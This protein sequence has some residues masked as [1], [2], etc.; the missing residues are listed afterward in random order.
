MSTVGLFNLFD[1]NPLRGIIE[2][3]VDFRALNKKSPIE[4]F[5]NATHAQSGAAKIF[6]TETISLDAVMASA[7]LPFIFKTVTVDDEPYWDGGF[8]GCPSLT[9]LTEG[10]R[11]SDIILV[12]AHPSFIEDV[13][14][15]ATD[16]LDRV[17]EIGFNAVLAQEIKMIET[18]RKSFRV[19]RIEA[20]DTLVSLGRASKLNA[21]W[22]FLVHLHDLGSQAATDWLDKWRR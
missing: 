19:H 22:D 6:T 12:Q 1:L 5:I 21:D 4:I 8:S 7:C 14:T 2:E 10:K 16:I 17:I 3:M 13:P 15:T 20:N 9:P 11:A 18:Y